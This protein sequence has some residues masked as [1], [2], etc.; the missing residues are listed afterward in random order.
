MTDPDQAA[1]LEVFVYDPTTGALTHRHTT[2]SGTQGELATFSHSRGYLS[3]SIG[4]K[5]YLAHRVIFMMITGQWP[6]HVDH[7]NHI[8]HDNRW[9]NLR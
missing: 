3:V 4:K 5:Q 8:K 7:I 6:E 9:E 2:S 1:L